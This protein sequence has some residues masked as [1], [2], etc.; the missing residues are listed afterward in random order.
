MGMLRNLFACPIFVEAKL[1]LRA[2]LH[3]LN[4]YYDMC[5]LVAVTIR[6]PIYPCKITL[7]QN[8]ITGLFLPK[9]VVTTQWS[10]E[11]S[12]N[13]NNMKKIARR[14]EKRSCWRPW[15]RRRR[16]RA[17]PARE[18]KFSSRERWRELK[19]HGNGQSPWECGGAWREPRPQFSTNKARPRSSTNEPRHPV[20]KHK[21]KKTPNLELFEDP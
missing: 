15:R 6:F 21:Q 12:I 10:L 20:F 14:I 3:G 1:N 8:Y 18:M 17:A 11:A 7:G 9:C 16:G 2:I 5:W 4:F 19:G 13:M